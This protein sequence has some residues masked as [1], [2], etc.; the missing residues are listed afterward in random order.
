MTTLVGI[1]TL[2]N[3]LQYRTASFSIPFDSLLNP[4]TAFLERPWNYLPAAPA[5]SNACDAIVF[6]NVI[7][8]VIVILQS[9]VYFQFFFH[10]SRCA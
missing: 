5:N 8:I 2:D 7:V 6:V 9:N 10:V 1:S 4:K 3:L